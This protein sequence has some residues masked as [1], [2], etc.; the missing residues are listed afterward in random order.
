MNFQDQRWFE[1]EVIKEKIESNMS[2]EAP[3]FAGFFLNTKKSEM[4]G[5]RGLYFQGFHISVI[6]TTGE[7][8]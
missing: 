8:F 3:Q 5:V 6:P 4:L 2:S 7:I 1:T